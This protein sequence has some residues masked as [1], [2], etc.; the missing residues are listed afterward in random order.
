M[1]TYV[2]R[3]QGFVSNYGER[4]RNGERTASGF[5]ESAVNQVVKT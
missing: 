2:K 1:H 4:N 5:V 3:N